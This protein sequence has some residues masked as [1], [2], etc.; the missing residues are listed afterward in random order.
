MPKG[1]SVKTNK[2]TA[3]TRLITIAEDKKINIKLKKLV[4]EA[5]I[6]TYAHV[7]AEGNNEGDI[8]CDLVAISV[9]WDEEMDC[10]V[11][12]TGLAMESDKHVGIFLFP[13]SSNR[14]TNCYLANS[15]GLIDTAIYRGELLFCYKPRTDTKISAKEY[16]LNETL[17]YIEKNLVKNIFNIFCIKKFISNIKTCYANY[18]E[19]YIKRVKNLELAPYKVG[20]K[21]GQMVAFDVKDISFEITDKLSETSR[22]ENGF[23]STDTKVE[24]EKK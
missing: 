24:K 11:Y 5:V 18:Y 13:R 12:H 4:D 6:P 8:G 17:N 15:V 16:A 23:G 1:K 19:N 2:G 3:A 9:N 14:K 21:V 7:D 22:G 20:D 10:Y